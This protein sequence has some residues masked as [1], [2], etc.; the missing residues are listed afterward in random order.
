MWKQVSE[1]FSRTLH[2]GRSAVFYRALVANILVAIDEFGKQRLSTID[3]S[4]ASSKGMKGDICCNS[5]AGSSSTCCRES[6]SSVLQQ[7]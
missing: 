7:Q 6:C 1:V 4:L 3:L 2:V 5:R